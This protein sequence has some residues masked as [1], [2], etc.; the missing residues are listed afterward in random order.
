VRE[1]R[2][3]PGP[4]GQ[5]PTHRGERG[6]AQCGPDLV[7][8]HHQA[9]GDTGLALGD[10][11]HRSHGDRH[12][13]RADAQAEDEQP[14]QHATGVRRSGVDGAQQRGAGRGHHQTGDGQRPRAD[15]RQQA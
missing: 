6:H 10:L 4:G 7:P 11:A 3:Q 2:D 14:G 1:A 9:G 15:R 13:H 12:E 5:V 8:G